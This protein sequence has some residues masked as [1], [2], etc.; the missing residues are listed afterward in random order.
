[1]DMRQFI[2]RKA[3]YLV[4]TLLA[5]IIFN[6]ALFRI[7]PG[8][9]AR[10]L[11]P[12]G[13]TPEMI[14]FIHEKY[15]LNDPLYVQLGYYLKDVFTGELGYSGTVRPFAPIKDMIGPP[16]LN[17]VL[18]VGFGTAIA[19]WLGIMLGRA[20]AWRRGKAADTVGMA[21]AITFYSMPTFLFALVMVML[22]GG[23][24]GWF[25]IGNA[26][27]ALPGNPDP[28]PYSDFTL[29]E[30]IVSRGYHLILPVLAFA[31]EVM[32]E[33]ALIMRNSLTDVLTEDYI[34]TARAKGLSNARILHDHAMRNALLPVVTVTAISVG[35]VLG[36]DIMVEIVF[37]YDGLGLLTW[38]AVNG[39]D[40]TLLQSLFLIMAIA[41]LAA[42]L[43][44]DLLYVYLDPR[45]HV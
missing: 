41:V 35:W 2:T 15:H 21:F 33:F 12:R 38:E 25:P 5:I 43:L 24:L 16:A 42:N 29:S 37:N 17:T 6:F 27:G 30:K 3:I 4:I 31:A 11:V 44:A 22:F 45:V 7:M 39:R 26:Y 9:P 20:A 13:A 19:V 36:G 23:E 32:A 34:V 40:F 28:G 18:L 10:V 8:D 1:M 14:D